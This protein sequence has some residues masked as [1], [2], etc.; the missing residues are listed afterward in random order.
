QNDWASWL[1]MAQFSYNIKQYSATGQAPFTVT[2]SYIHRMGIEPLNLKNKMATGTARDMETVL[3]ATKSALGRAAKRM[4]ES[5][6]QHRS[7]TPEYQVGD[8]VW[9]SSEHLKV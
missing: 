1:K 6:D 4:K 3:E 8:L 5:A 7:D 9:L 2:R